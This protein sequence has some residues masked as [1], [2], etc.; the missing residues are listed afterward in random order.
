MQEKELITVQEVADI[1]EHQI[2]YKMILQLVHEKKLIAKKIGRKYYFSRQY[3]LEK[4][5]KWFN[6][7]VI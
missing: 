7:P 2:S 6:I 3:C 5:R 4:K 1:F